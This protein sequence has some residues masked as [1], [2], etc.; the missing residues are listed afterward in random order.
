MNE[1]TSSEIKSI[2]KGVK[3]WNKYTL[4]DYQDCL[5]KNEA[6]CGIIILSE[7]KTWKFNDKTTRDSL[8]HF[9]W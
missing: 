5:E 8:K 6:K 2:Q 4:E 3:Q 7:E 9:W 1:K